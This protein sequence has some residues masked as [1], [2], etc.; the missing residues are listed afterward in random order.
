[1]KLL[2]WKCIVGAGRVCTCRLKGAAG[3]QTSQS[4]KVSLSRTP[5][6]TTAGVPVCVGVGLYMCV[7]NRS[8]T[9]ML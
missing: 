9:I 5:L 1:M 4:V 6:I 7:C 3:A 8:V 2:M